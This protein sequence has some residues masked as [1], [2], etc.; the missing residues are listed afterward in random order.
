LPCPKAE[1]FNQVLQ[2]VRGHEKMTCLLSPFRTANSIYR[3]V[4]HQQISGECVNTYADG[5]WMMHDGRFVLR[6]SALVLRSACLL[7]AL[8]R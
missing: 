8:M 5:R 4:C 3:F 6:A 1:A 2:P 7:T